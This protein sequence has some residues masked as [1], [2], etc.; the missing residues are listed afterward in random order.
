MTGVQ[1]CALPICLSKIGNIRSCRAYYIPEATEWDPILIHF[2]G[3]FYMKD[4]ITAADINN[5]SG[6][7]QY[8]VGG[9]APGA[10]AFFRTS[11]RKAPHNE[12]GR[13]S[14]RE[15]VWLMV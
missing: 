12:I 10:G 7:N 3:V 13:A 8:G 2:G 9:G 5:I 11:D 1:T 15:R 4:R 14:C 6:T